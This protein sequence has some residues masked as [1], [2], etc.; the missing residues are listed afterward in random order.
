MRYCIPRIFSFV[1][2]REG[3]VSSIGNWASSKSTWIAG[4]R[5]KIFDL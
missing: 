4:L 3:L 1:V 2:N 5:R